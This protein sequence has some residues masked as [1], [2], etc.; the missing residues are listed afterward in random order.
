MIAIIDL[1]YLI[2]CDFYKKREPDIFKLNG[3][4]LLTLVFM[5]DSFLVY[6]FLLENNGSL[7]ITFFGN[8]LYFMLV[9]VLLLM[10]TFYIRYSKYMTYEKIDS[11]LKSMDRRIGV[12]YYLLSVCFVILSV[13]VPI[14]YV[15]I[16]GGK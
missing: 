8:G 2:C 7:K 11:K 6:M 1:P 15:I 5:L 4:I 9:V 13:T 14:I 3:I 10:P 12:F 16:Y